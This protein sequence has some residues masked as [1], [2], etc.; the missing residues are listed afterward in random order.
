MGNATGLFALA[1]NLA[2]SIGI[3]VVTTMASRGAQT[4]QATLVTHV[5][6]YDTAFQNAVQASQAALAGHVGTAQA[7]SGALSQIYQ[8]MLQQANLLAY[9]DDFR[10]LGMICL[11]ALPLVLLLKRVVVKGGPMLAH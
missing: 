7:H 4:H 3:S 9:L 5:T 10:L 6:P 2:G 1:R 8:Q 11:I